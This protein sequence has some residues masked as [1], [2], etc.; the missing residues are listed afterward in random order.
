MRAGGLQT[1]NGYILALY[2]ISGFVRGLHRSLTLRFTL[3]VFHMFIF[4][5][6]FRLF[7]SFCDLIVFGSVDH[8]VSVF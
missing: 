1:H 2:D 7:N 6:V 4:V 8:V 3:F 5:I